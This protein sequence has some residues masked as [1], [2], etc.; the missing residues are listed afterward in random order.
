MK[1]LVIHP[2]DPTTGFLKTIY[3]E[4]E[5][6][7]I[8]HDVNKEDMMNTIKNYDRVY[9]MGHGTPYGLLGFNCYVI[10]EDFVEILENKI[11]VYIW[12]HANLFCSKFN[13]KGL[14]TGMIV[15]EPEEAILYSLPFHDNEIIASNDLFAATLSKY[16]DQPTLFV[17]ILEEYYNPS[18]TI[19]E[20]NKNNI[21]I[22]DL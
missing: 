3:Q 8:N 14:K 11:C 6:S 5:W 13:L 9:M 16:I 18:N 2:E 4:K 22:D 12:C 17:K 19:I 20:F 21:I 15:S 7:V 1:T 10:D